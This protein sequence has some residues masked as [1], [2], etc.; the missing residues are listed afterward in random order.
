MSVWVDDRWHRKDGSRSNDYGVRLRWRVRWRISRTAMRS[1]C[2]ERK[3][4]AERYRQDLELR[5]RH[6]DSLD[7]RAGDVTFGDLAAKWLDGM[8]PPMTT[9][10]TY[11]RYDTSLRCQVSP[12]FRDVPISRIGHSDVTTWVADLAASGLSRSTI[13]KAYLNLNQVLDFAVADGL[14]PRNRTRKVKMPPETPKPKKHYLS[15]DELVRLA[16][17]STAPEHILLLGYCGMRFGESIALDVRDLDFDAGRIEI[18][19]SWSE[20]SGHLVPGS[21]KTHRRRS[22]PMPATIAEMLRDHTR[23]RSGLVFPN[24]EGGVIRPRNW[25]TRVLDKAVAVTDL[26]PFTPHDLRHTAV[27]IAVSAGA[28]IRVIAEMVGH[29]DPSV[30]LDEYAELFSSD[31]DQLAVSL[32]TRLT[33]A[34]DRQPRLRVV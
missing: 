9:L 32:D 28:N 20:V 13:L 31:L 21:T 12:T 11:T 34:L 3:A 27:S 15:D 10:G 19:K 26:G 33:A 24:S 23:G 6:G 25:R 18:R 7:P 16:Y 4:D 22:V 30:T 1:K 14:V 17:A 29:K 2:F 5:Q 8:R